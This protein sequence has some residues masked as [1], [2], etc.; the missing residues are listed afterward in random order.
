MVNM[1]AT[2]TWSG[3]YG[4]TP[5]TAI[6]LGVSGNLFNFKRLDSLTGAADYT[7]YPIT[8]GENSYEVWLRGK[9]TGTFNKVQN[10]QFWKS[11]PTGNDTGVSIKWNGQ[12]TAYA[13]PTTANS[14]IATA[15]VPTEDPGTANVSIGGALTGSLSA[16]GYSDY[17]VLQMR[18][19]TGAAAGDTSAYTFTMQY[20][21]N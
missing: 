3:V 5:G 8:A 9:W 10:L 11:S 13:T 17:I 21:E 4:T 7:S 19:T 6:D 1:A 14:S 15:D 16:S 2:W 18:T 12:R 20:D